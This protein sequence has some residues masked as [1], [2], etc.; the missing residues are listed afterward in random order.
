MNFKGFQYLPILRRS[1]IIRSYRRT[2]TCKI[3]YLA[4]IALL[5]NAW[6]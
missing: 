5:C 3:A 2:K 1:I 4:A 6:F